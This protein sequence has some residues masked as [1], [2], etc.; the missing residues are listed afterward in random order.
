MTLGRLLCLPLPRM[1]HLS[2]VD[3]FYNLHVNTHI[4]RTLSDTPSSHHHRVCKDSLEHG[5]ARDMPSLSSTFAFLTDLLSPEIGFLHSNTIHRLGYK[6]SRRK[7][8]S[9]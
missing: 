3:W 1:S 5:V 9:I 6:N 2:N 7:N 8:S 4:S